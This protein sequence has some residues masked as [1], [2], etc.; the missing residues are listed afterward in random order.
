MV[1]S[2]AT[3]DI[4]VND[5]VNKSG[6]LFGDVTAS[7]E[8]HRSEFVP[9]LEE[10]TPSVVW[11]ERLGHFLTRNHGHRI[12]L[13]S[14]GITVDIDRRRTLPLSRALG[15]HFHLKLDERS[16]SLRFDSHTQR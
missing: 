2:F 9:V 4:G 13:H 11:D 16:D 5:L 14:D 15:V 8:V 12:G 7:T 10:F 3:S 1:I 6:F